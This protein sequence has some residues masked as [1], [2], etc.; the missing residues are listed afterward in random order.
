MAKDSSRLE[1]ALLQGVVDAN[2][3][4]PF[5]GDNM[6]F[7]RPDDGTP[8]GRALVLPSQPSVFT[9]GDDGEDAHAGVLQIDL[10]YPLMQGTADVSAK[11]DE[12]EEFFKAGR[13]LQYSG[14]EVLILSCGRS[15]GRE[16]D[17]WYRVS[18]TVSWSA[19]VPRN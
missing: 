6:P 3:S 8:W 7:D 13:R 16:V 14:A 9:L 4:L 10:N 17:G 18:M 12:V 15:R 5:S 2:L 1:R 19:R 11:A